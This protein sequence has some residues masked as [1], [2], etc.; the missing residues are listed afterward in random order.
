MDAELVEGAD[1]GRNCRAIDQRLLR[2]HGG[3]ERSGWIY[4]IRK[5]TGN[6]IR[7]VEF[8]YDFLL[9]L[10]GFLNV[11]FALKNVEFFSL[12]SIEF[13]HICFIPDDLRCQENEKIEF[14][15]LTALGSKEPAQ[16][17]DVSKKGNLVFN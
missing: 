4:C 1:Q 8:F 12:P 3:L 7:A 2:S 15:C 6:S 13:D 11:A 9:K 5:G 17:G 16:Q 10:R 14:V